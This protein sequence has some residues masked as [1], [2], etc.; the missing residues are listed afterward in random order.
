MD[1]VLIEDLTR[2]Y[3]IRDERDSVQKEILGESAFMLR[4]YSKCRLLVTD[5]Y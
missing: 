2:I 5:Q 1:N 4:T 3:S